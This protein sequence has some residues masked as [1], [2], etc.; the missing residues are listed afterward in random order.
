V[1]DPV[2]DC[3][4]ELLKPEIRDRGSAAEYEHVL[5]PPPER[6]GRKSLPDWAGTGQQM[7]GAAGYLPFGPESPGV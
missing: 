5:E 3:G 4:E 6:Q 2:T 7:A 1:I